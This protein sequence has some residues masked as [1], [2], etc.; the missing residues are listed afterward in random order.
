VS[1]YLPRRSGGPGALTLVSIFTVYLA[2][3][4]AKTWP[5]ALHF[6]THLPAPSYSALHV[7]WIL[8]W[9]AHGL[10]TDPRHLFDANLL[11]PLDRSLAF[12]EHLLG[13]QPL[14]APVYALS[15]TPTPGYNMLFV[16]S[17]ALSAFSAFCLVHHLTGHRWAAFAAGALFGFAPFRFGHIHHLHV[18]VFFWAPLALLFLDR[19]LRGR[20]WPDLAAFAVFSWLQVLTSVYTA[21]MLTLAVVVLAGYRALAVDRGLRSRALVVPTATFVLTSLLVLGL[22]HLPYVAVRRAWGRPWTLGA[23]GGGSADLQAYLTAPPL[24]SDLYVQLSRLVNPAPADDRMLFPGLVLPVLALLG[25]L[26]SE[27]GVP[28][29]RARGLRG[30]WGLLV[31]VAL[32]LSLGP[33]LLVWG[34]RTAVPLP[35]WILYHVVPGWGATRIPARLAL[36][37]VLAAT[38]LA[39]LGILRCAEAL[40]ARRRPRGDVLVALAVV[41]AAFLE[42][43]TRPLPLEETPITRVPAAYRWLATER[44]GPVVE[45]PM[46]LDVEMQYLYLSTVHW[47]PVVSAGSSVSPRAHQDLKEGLEDLPAPRALARAGALGARAIVL[48]TDRMSAEAVARW[49]TREARDPTLRRLGTFPP[50]L[51]YAVPALATAPR[52]TARMASL[53]WAPA[54]RLARL[55]LLVSGADGRAWA[56]PPPMAQSVAHITWTHL[57][58]GYT[59]TATVRGSFPLALAPGETAVVPLRVQTPDVPGRYRLHVTVPGRAIESALEMVEIRRV[60]PPTSAQARQALAATYRLAGAP[61]AAAALETL[62]LGLTAGN[63]GQAVWL[64]KAPRER[65]DVAL[66]WRWLHGTVEVPMPARRMRVRHDV[67]PG[68][69]YSFQVVVPTPAAPGAYVLELG[70]VSE[71]VATFA[72]AGSPPLR[73]PIR[74]E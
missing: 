32:V 50:H 35:Y 8:A 45:L 51:V 14:F 66:R 17:F 60:S 41:A 29:D 69:A 15:G 4:L 16:L 70:L 18:L 25:V 39:A 55:G 65:G 34:E 62:D 38:P 68:Q 46:G 21:F 73:L 43:G 9:G 23:I 22:I 47:L 49:T 5:L 10:A 24:L 44:P 54:A 20:R 33:Y 30:A 71:G 64:A 72:E 53:P 1:E 48:H 74:V 61:A 12:N 37:A 11:Y 19:F 40:R 57:D 27:P 2:L 31:L 63:T 26:R 42:L 28:A 59:T 58:T 67:F 36:L 6:T 56:H 3:A 7:G 13:L 52:L